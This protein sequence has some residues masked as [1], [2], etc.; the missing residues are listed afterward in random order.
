M[1]YRLRLSERVLPEYREHWTQP[2]VLPKQAEIHDKHVANGNIISVSRTVDPND[3]YVVHKEL[4]Y[5]SKEIADSIFAELEAAGI[6]LARPE[7]IEA[8]DVSGEEIPD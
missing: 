7:G 6:L 8:Y 3:P 5:K 2:E 1:R 4:I